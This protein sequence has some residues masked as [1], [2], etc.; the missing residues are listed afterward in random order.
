MG[1]AVSLPALIEEVVEQP[2]PQNHNKPLKF[3]TKEEELSVHRSSNPPVAIGFT[4]LG[5]VQLQLLLVVP[6]QRRLVLSVR[7]HAK[8]PSKPLHVV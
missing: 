7:L 4:F 3:R 1:A 5:L 2:H 8:L 6:S